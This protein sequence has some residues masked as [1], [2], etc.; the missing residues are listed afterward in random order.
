MLRFGL[1][2]HPAAEAML[3]DGLELY[4]LTTCRTSCVPPILQLQRGLEVLRSL[5]LMVTSLSSV[6]P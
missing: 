2:H 4:R 6:I 1:V 5:L 3:I